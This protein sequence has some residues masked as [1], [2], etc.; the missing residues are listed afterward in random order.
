[1]HRSELSRYSFQVGAGWQV[2]YNEFYG[3]DPETADSIEGYSDG[4]TV[5]NCHFNEDL[6]Q[7]RNEQRGLLIDVGWYP[8]YD[9]TGHYK[10]RVL[11]W[12]LLESG[13]MGFDWLHPISV[14]TTRRPEE[15]VDFVEALC[16]QDSVNDSKRSAP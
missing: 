12:R 10:A 11:S 2:T 9:P 6:V 16:R 13:E 1:M 14:L 15:V 5:W 7:I 8:Y 3:V 4:Y